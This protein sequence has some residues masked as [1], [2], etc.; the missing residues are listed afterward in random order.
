MEE[1]YSMAWRYQ[2]VF[3]EEDGGRQYGACEVHF[4][5]NGKLEAWSEIVEP[6]GDTLESFR[7]SL[8]M[9]LA[10]AKTWKPVEFSELEVG[11]EFERLTD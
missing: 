5:D 1:A 6:L 4:D 3:I 2:P 9:M 11:F 8:A 7:E 10:D